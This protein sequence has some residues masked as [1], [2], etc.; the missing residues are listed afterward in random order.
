MG[1]SPSASFAYPG[2]GG[3]GWG[4]GLAA[5]WSQF[6]ACNSAEGAQAVFSG[7]SC[8]LTCSTAPHH[9][10]VQSWSPDRAFFT[11]SQGTHISLSASLR[12]CAESDQ[13]SLHHNMPPES[14]P[15]SPGDSTAVEAWG[16]VECMC[17]EDLDSF[18]PAQFG[19]L[20]GQGKTP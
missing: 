5:L 20:P 3:W 7:A 8:N 17:L 15:S 6:S 18:N 12:N 16:G 4:W 10:I 9:T 11:P 19:G 1:A 13:G 14:Y 2:A